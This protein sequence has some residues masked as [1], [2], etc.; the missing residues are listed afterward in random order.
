MKVPE[1]KPVVLVRAEVMCRA[2]DADGVVREL[3]HAFLTS[4]AAQFRLSPPKVVRKVR[5]LCSDGMDT[6]YPDW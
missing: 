5:N 3:I 4:D 2:D 6:L 1:N